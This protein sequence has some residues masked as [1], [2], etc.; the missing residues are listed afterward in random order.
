LDVLCAQA[1]EPQARGDDARFRDL[2]LGLITS[3]MGSIQRPES[4]IGGNRKPLGEIMM[5][6]IVTEV[7]NMHM[8]VVCVAGWD[9]KEKRMVRPLSGSGHHWNASFARP[10][11]YQVGNV[12]QLAPSGDC[13]QRGMPH[14][15]EDFVV[16]V[17]PAL[18]GRIEQGDL[19]SAIADS[20]SRTVEEIFDGN[21]VESRLVMAGA[22]CPSLGAVRVNPRR[23]GFE[24]KRKPNGPDQLRCWFYD[25]S[26][27]RYNLPV[28]SRAIQSINSQEGVSAVNALKTGSQQAH[29]RIGLAHP[30]DDGRAFAMVNHVL[31]S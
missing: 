25:E 10:D 9:G 2:T 22:D 1:E 19:P 28:T 16:R 15:H 7:T 18:V 6:I 17:P 8:G 27:D 31:F 20:E 21:L 11:L 30:F 14:A 24:L 3:M 5:N 23:M 12:V 4:R 29:V 13:T 26:N